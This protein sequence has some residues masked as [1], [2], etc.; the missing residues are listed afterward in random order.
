MG[1]KESFSKLVK[2]AKKDPDIIGFF[3]NGSRGKNQETKFS[4]YDIEVVVK[5]KVANQY[6]DK[7]KKKNKPPFGFSVF[8]ISVSNLTFKIVKNDQS[9]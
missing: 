3:L 8:S 9:K 5:D 7:Y 1:H 4:D 6:K 2:E